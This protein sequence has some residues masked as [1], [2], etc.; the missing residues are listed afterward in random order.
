MKNKHGTPFEMVNFMFQI[1]CPIF[2]MRELVRHRIAS[3]NEMSG[4]YTKLQ[5]KFYIPAIE[6][7]RQQTGK[8]G[9]Y[10]FEPMAPGIAMT[11]RAN[12]A[13]S[14]QKSWEMYE[15]LL[16]LGVAKELARAIL[17]VGIYTSL[18]WSLNLRSL[19]NFI[20]LRSAENAMYEI[21]C[22]SQAI[23]KL[24]QPCVPVAFECFCKN[25]RIAP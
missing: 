6:D 8:P 22:F 14:Y 2:V 13:L 19:F 3:I 18:T 16:S 20:S 5:P 10:T 24:I 15:E 25:G 21:R 9:N 4:R 11:V 17:P 23:E 1:R 12:M 7:V